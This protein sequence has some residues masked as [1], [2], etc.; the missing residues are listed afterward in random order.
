MAC[1]G[2]LIV[3]RAAIDVPRRGAGNVQRQQAQKDTKK[4]N[5]T[6]NNVMEMKFVLLL[7]IL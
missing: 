6:N 3:K 4:R 7:K 5:V 1:G 2:G